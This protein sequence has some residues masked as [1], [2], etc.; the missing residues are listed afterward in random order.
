MKPTDIRI[1]R[2]LGLFFLALAI[3]IPT[4]L[5]FIAG[6]HAFIVGLSS[7]IILIAFGILFLS[8]RWPNSPRK[9]SK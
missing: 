2:L 6:L 5:W 3:A 8:G 9:E 4:F 7:A 1:Q